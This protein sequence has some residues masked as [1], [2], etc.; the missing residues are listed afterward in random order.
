MAKRTRNNSTERKIEKWIKEG[1][2]QG[3]GEIINLGWKFKMLLQMVMLQE[4]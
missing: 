3:E 1:R 2:G 4:I